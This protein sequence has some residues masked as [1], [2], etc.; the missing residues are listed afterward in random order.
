MLTGPSGPVVKDITTRTI[1]VHGKARRGAPVDS[2][3]LRGSIRWSVIQ[4][5]NDI[6]GIVGTDVDYAI[7]VHNGTRY[8][9]ARPFLLNALREAA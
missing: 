5:G 4:R 3:R 6:V 8:M 7:Y 1:R 9:S 2:G